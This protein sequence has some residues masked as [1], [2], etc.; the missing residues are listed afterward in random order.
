MHNNSKMRNKQ[1][2]LNACKILPFFKILRTH[3]FKMTPFYGFREFMLPIEKI[4]LFRENGFIP[5]FVVYVLVGS[6]EAGVQGDCQWPLKNGGNS[7]RSCEPMMHQLWGFPQFVFRS[8]NDTADSTADWRPCLI[9][10][11]LSYYHQVRTVK[12][13]S[14]WLAIFLVA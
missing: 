6:G 14:A 2:V 8:T 3:A 4:P 5:I 11:W 13:S 9:T 10:H 7:H 12:Q 1:I